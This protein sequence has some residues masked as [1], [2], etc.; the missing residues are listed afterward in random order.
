M[1][2]S[3]PI[4]ASFMLFKY[5]SI[6]PYINLKDRMYFQ[7]MSYGWNDE[8]QELQVDTTTG[9]YNV[10]DFNT[11]ISLSTKIYGFYTPLKR[12]FPNSRVEKFRHVITPTLSFNYHPNFEK[13][14]W[15]Y[16]SEYDETVYYADSLDSN[17]RKVPTGQTIHHV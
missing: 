12:L 7:R 6:T 1:Q 15:G 16:Y 13:S 10:F 5:L 8:T 14:G 4:S 17:Y 11:G 9:F 2:H 3:V